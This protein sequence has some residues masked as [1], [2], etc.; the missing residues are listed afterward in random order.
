MTKQDKIDFI[1]NHPEHHSV[2]H[3]NGTGYTNIPE[4]A[5]FNKVLYNG[6]FQF[7]TTFGGNP[8]N[9]RYF[10]IDLDQADE[11]IVNQLFDPIEE[12]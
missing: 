10:N 4:A 9:T 8:D 11:E 6:V 1:R 5:S 2:L 3:I 12:L 7:T